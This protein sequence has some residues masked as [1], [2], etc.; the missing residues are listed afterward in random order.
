MRSI[1]N[2]LLNYIENEDTSGSNYS[3]LTKLFDD[4]KIRQNKHEL[5]LLLHLI[6]VISNNHQRFTD[7]FTKIFQIL[8]DLQNEIKS[9]FSNLSI[10]NIFR[11][12]KRILLYLIDERILFIDK[13]IFSIIKTKKYSKFYYPEYFLTEIRP[14]VSTNY[15][16]SIMSNMPEEYEHFRRV[17]EGYFIIV[18]L[19]MKDEIDKFI[20]YVNEHNLSLYNE[21]EIS[22]IETNPIILK[23]NP[24]LIEYA[25]FYSSIKII[26][27]LIENGVELTSSLWFYAIHSNNLDIIHLLESHKVEEPKKSMK[28]V[29]WES[30]KCHHIKMTEYLLK[31]KYIKVNSKWYFFQCLKYY[32]FNFLDEKLIN[33]SSFFTFCKYDYFYL[34]DKFMNENVNDTKVLLIFFVYL[35]SLNFFLSEYLLS[36]NSMMFQFCIV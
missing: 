7:F 14:F 27:Y 35:I 29:V 33:E 2:S 18:E 8:R 13:T 17:G 19:I 26:N 6:S 10:F 25:F 36:K 28:G 3:N 22:I 5:K 34:V 15:V 31:K 9:F 4:I 16:N 23:N 11:R 32:N 30:I 24:S 20:S 1:Q 21:P 12:N